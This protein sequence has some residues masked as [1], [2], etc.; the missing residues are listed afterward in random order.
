MSNFG[1]PSL[2]SLCRTALF[3][4][5]QSKFGSIETIRNQV[6]PTPVL[7]SETISP[8]L[9][10]HT[11]KFLQP[12]IDGRPVDAFFIKRVIQSVIE[13]CYSE[14]LHP[15]LTIEPQPRVAP[16][17]DTVH[18]LLFEYPNAANDLFT[19]ML[20]SYIA[21]LERY[22]ELRRLVV[23]A[24]ID[25]LSEAGVA[26]RGAFYSPDDDQLIEMSF[27]SG[28]QIDSV[29]C[30]C[31]SPHVHE[32]MS[33]RFQSLGLVDVNSYQSVAIMDDKFE[34]CLKWLGRGV[35]T[36]EA[37]LIRNAEFDEDT[38]ENAIHSVLDRREEENS[39]VVIQPNHGTE[40]RDVRAF[41][42]NDEN[43]RQ[44]I[45]QHIQAITHYDDVLMRR[46]VSGA[47]LFNKETNERARFD[48][49]VNVVSGIAESG[50][51]IAAPK[52]AVIASP[53]QGGRI[54][55]WNALGQYRID[56]EDEISL[57]D[58]S[59]L[60]EVQFCATQAVRAFG[61]GLT[62]GVDLRIGLTNDDRRIEAWVLDVNPR[63]AGLGRSC[64]WN[65]EPGV[66]RRLWS[67]LPT[68]D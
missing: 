53:S 7:L 62:A 64:F 50:Y 43:A 36:P 32:A 12:V 23:A 68:I 39:F 67:V 30:L 28:V 11:G 17:C 54:V 1:G 18:C 13:D 16:V 3:E 10:Q 49:R 47:N 20:D 46:G 44:A 52:N 55:E 42:L 14:R 65:G 63:P 51:G 60:R 27:D 21:D 5:L 8:W 41:F 15:P 34:C 56:A 40:G 4:A 38:I 61:E 57:S 58:P 31:M 35:R 48:I 25:W 33:K 19:L 22:G 59:L 66:T 26:M 9:D 6:H 29:H 2:S 37:E 24:H 45:T